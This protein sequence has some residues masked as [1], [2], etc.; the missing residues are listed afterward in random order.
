MNVEQK[1]DL[2][3]EAHN[4]VDLLNN[5]WYEFFIQEGDFERWQPFC[6]MNTGSQEWWEGYTLACWI[7]NRFT[8]YWGPEWSKLNSDT[9]KGIKEIKKHDN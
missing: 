3:L 8:T 1:R 6:Y 7:M 9:L 4:S 2:A 5:G